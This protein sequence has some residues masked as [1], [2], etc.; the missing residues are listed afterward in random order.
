MRFNNA[1]LVEQI[2]WDMRLADQPRG[3]NRALIDRLANGNPPFTAAEQEAGH[4]K[5]NVN[6]LEFPELLADARRAYA[7][8]FMKQGK[9]FNITLD[10]GPV[11]KRREWSRIITRELNR[12]LKRSRAYF[13]SLRSQFAMTVEHGIGPV[14]WPDRFSAVPRPTGIEDVLVPSGTRLTMDNLQHFAVFRETVPMELYQWT[15]GR[16]VDEGWQMPTVNAAIE[17]ANQQARAMPGYADLF[18]P[19]KVEA[20][21]KQDLGFYGSDAVPTINIWDF[22]FWSDEGHKQGWRRRMILDTPSSY[23]VAGVKGKT[24]MPNKNQIGQDHGHWLYRPK[25]D[26]VYADSLEQIVHW[27]F[28][29]ASAVAP[30]YY[31]AVRGLGWLL[32]APCHLQNRYRCRL[33]DAGFEALLQYFRTTNEEDKERILKIDLQHL[34]VVPA[35]V[36]FVRQ[37]ERWKVD[38]QLAALVVGQNK[39]RM[40]KAAAQYREGRDSATERKEKTAT[41]IMAEVNASNA[42]VGAL[43]LQAYTY[44]T[45]KGIE[46]ARRSCI[47]DSEDSGVRQFRVNCLK[48]GVDERYLNSDLWDV[49]VE[50]MMGSGNKTL[51][52]AMADKLMAARGNLDAQAQREVDHTYVLANSDDPDYANRL[53]P[54]EGDHEPSPTPHDAA[55]AMSS[56]LEGIPVPP[57]PGENQREVVETWLAGMMK[58]MELLKQAGL[59]TM[60]DLLGLENVAANIGARLQMMA[61]DKSNA[62]RLKGYAKALAGAMKVVQ[63]MKKL[64]QKMAQQGGENGAAQAAAQEARIKA[65]ATAAQAA[66]KLKTTAA[67][68]AQRTREKAQTAAQKLRQSEESHQA[69]LRKQAVQTA[70]DLEEQ[71]IRTQSDIHNNRLKAL[72]EPKEGKDGS[73]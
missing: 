49:E 35:G 23:E 65:Q 8:A 60:K 5:T 67:S 61:Q 19:E 41:E 62:G 48:A 46:I 1:A 15:H 58:R 40:E 7:N 29:D 59:P 12:M 24:P 2:V 54:M 28:G 36:N 53:V 37:E 70:A 31:H 17:W 64:V 34:G 6:F 33:N 16:K 72:A 71:A 47:K 73:D 21:W 63:A 39:E 32:F 50:R 38:Y 69:E 13:E 14:V 11:R 52:I 25:D 27:Q 30:F 20:R 55:V 43:M 10:Y 45:F 56:L 57:K 4:I 26:R 44:E 66:L 22:Y 18:A 42:L 68:H 3:Q 51:Q 9:F